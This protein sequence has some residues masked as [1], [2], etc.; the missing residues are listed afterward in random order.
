[1]RTAG[2]IGDQVAVRLPDVTG[3]QQRIDGTFYKS[4]AVSPVVRLAIHVHHVGEPG[5]GLRS[6]D[7]LRIA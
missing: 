1:L 6:Q 2:D 7:A 4:A 5:G 3:R